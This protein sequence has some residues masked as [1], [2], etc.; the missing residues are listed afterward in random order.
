MADGDHTFDVLLKEIRKDMNDI[1]DV[2]LTS[3]LPVEEY[4]K[5]QGTIDGL[6]RA[7]RMVLDFEARAAHE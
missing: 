7:E 2:I 3:P 1:A 4:R 6:A 5:L